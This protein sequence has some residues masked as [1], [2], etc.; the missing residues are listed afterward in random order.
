MI[1][2][3]RQTGDKFN[4]FVC[5]ASCFFFRRKGSIVKNKFSES[6][7]GRNSVMAF[8][9]A[10][11]FKHEKLEEKKS[12]NIVFFFFVTICSKARPERWTALK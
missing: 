8:Y 10:V 12:Q 3:R 1:T 7:F 4:V 2:G 5:I 11:L 9:L 6:C